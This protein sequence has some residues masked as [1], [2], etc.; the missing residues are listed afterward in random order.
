MSGPRSNKRVVAE[1]SRGAASSG[2]RLVLLAADGPEALEALG[3][4]PTPVVD[5]RFA[6]EEHALDRPPRRTDRGG[7]RVF[8]A[9]A[10]TS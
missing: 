4:E 6:E 10:P 5:V 1:L 7:I 3:L 8:V 9:P 2:H